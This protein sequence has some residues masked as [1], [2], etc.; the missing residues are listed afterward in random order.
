MVQ[1]SIIALLFIVALIFMIR[2]FMPKKG[3]QGG[4]G[5]GCGCA[6]SN[7]KQ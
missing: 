7:E 5:K 2:K 1:Y 3:K 6:L 4:C